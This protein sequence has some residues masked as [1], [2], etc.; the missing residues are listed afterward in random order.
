MNDVTNDKNERLLS[1]VEAAE[2]L[3]V[4]RQRV[5]VLISSGRLPATKV[6]AYYVIRESDLDLVRERT[7]GRP[8]RGLKPYPSWYGENIVKVDFVGG[9]QQPRG[10]D[11][12]PKE[13]KP[14]SVL[15]NFGTG[16]SQ[17]E[18]KNEPNP[19][20]NVTSEEFFAKAI[21]VAESFRNPE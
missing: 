1:V 2:E 18:W 11:G 15:V 10:A 4:N 19:I 20:G 9:V 7:P 17:A 13:Y 12:R 14:I 21:E 6:G 8:W 3:K 5:Q 16:S